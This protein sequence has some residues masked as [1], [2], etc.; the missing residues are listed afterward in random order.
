MR[1]HSDTN[2]AKS[3]GDDVRHGGLLRQ[4]EGE[5]A[6]PELLGELFGCFRPMRNDFMRSF[7]RCDMNDKRACVWTS[8]SVKDFCHCVGGECVGAESIDSFGR[9][10]DQAPSAQEFGGVTEFVMSRINH[11]WQY[12]ICASVRPPKPNA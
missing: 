5:W 11:H 4:D 12:R 3:G 10:S 8:F 7:R 2:R 9:E 6:R 1:R